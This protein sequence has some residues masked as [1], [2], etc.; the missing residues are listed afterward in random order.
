[1]DQQPSRGSSTSGGE[2]AQDGC[3][4]LSRRLVRGIE[5]ETNRWRGFSQVLVELGRCPAD[6]AGLDPGGVAL[7]E[8]LGV[9]RE[10]HDEDRSMMKHPKEPRQ[11]V[12]DDDVLDDGSDPSHGVA[13]GNLRREPMAQPELSDRLDGEWRRDWRLPGY[14]HPAKEI[15]PD[16]RGTWQ[17]FGQQLRDR[18]L[19]GRHR[20]RDDNDRG[21]LRFESLW[22]RQCPSPP[23]PCPP[24]AA[25]LID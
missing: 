16:V 4:G 22:Y 25:R 1:M 12:A 13:I 18:R 14:K 15:T 21:V 10:D 24:L 11:V 6:V 17:L 23:P 7:S 3:D 9:R 8:C 5:P 2:A 19:A 20:S